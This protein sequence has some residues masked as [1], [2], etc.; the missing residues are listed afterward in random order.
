MAVALGVGILGG[1]VPSGAQNC[2]PEGY[3]EYTVECIDDSGYYYWCCTEE[4]PVCCYNYYE[5]W[6]CPTGTSCGDGYTVYC[7]DQSPSTTTV[8]ASSTSSIPSGTTTIPSGTTTST[9]QGGTTTTTAA[10]STTTSVSSGPVQPGLVGIN[11]RGEDA[12]QT[13]SSGTLPGTSPSV[14]VPMLR[15]ADGRPLMLWYDRAPEPP[16][17]ELIEATFRR[18]A[19]RGSLTAAGAISDFGVGEQKDFWVKDDS[20]RAWRTVTATCQAETAS[21]F[22]FVDNT[23]SIP[24]ASIDDYATEFDTMYTVVTDNIGTFVDRDGN[25]KVSILLYDMNDS[26]SIN[27]YMGGYFWSKDYYDDATASRSG[28]RSNEMD[29]VYIRGDEPQGWEQTG[30]DFY[31][32]NLT[33]LVHEY[34]HLVHFGIKVWQP[35]NGYGA[36]DTWID[37]MMAMASETMYFK[38]KLTANPGYTHPAMTGNGYLSDRIEYYSGD[39]NSSIRN[40]HGLTYWDRNGDVYANYSLSYLFGQY[41]AL[42]STSGQAIFRQILDYM[43]ANNVNDFQAVAGAA[44][45]SIDGVSSWEDLLKG[46]AIANMANQPDGPYGYRGAFALTAHGPTQNQANVNNSGAVYRVTSGDL[47]IPAG[48]GPNMRFYD[49]AGTVVGEGTYTSSIPGTSTP[50]GPCAAAQ[51]LGEESAAAESLRAFRDTVLGGS[52]TG[53]ALTRQY[54]CHSAEVRTILANDPELRARARRVLLALVPFVRAT[55]QGEK[56]TLDENLAGE[57]AALCDDIGQEAGPGLRRSL[58]ELQR[59]LDLGEVPGFVVE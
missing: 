14:N 51:L 47:S 40:G 16:D 21:S 58:E 8:P 49:L 35:Q 26:G 25:G 19:R 31:A 13:E 10:A 12:S 45:Q 23:L 4:Y 52:G 53:A 1:A 57:L 48:A 9:I 5:Q 41:M 29:I 15:R 46:F 50:G 30:E 55:L 7:V 24:A 42:Q 34:Q 28:L 3:P 33:T 39:H 54:Y 20:D 17:P 27:G 11:I 43:L 56:V 22:I 18:L 38:A 36:S 6:C 44:G 59:A 32:Y 37:E 2:P